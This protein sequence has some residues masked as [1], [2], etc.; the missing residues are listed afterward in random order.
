MSGAVW[1]TKSPEKGGGRDVG[2][3]R[4]R[5]TPNAGRRR[6]QPS[7]AAL[8]FPSSSAGWLAGECSAFDAWRCRVVQNTPLENWRTGELENTPRRRS[9]A[10]NSRLRL[11]RAHLPPAFP[12]VWWRPLHNGARGG[13]PRAQRS[14]WRRHERR[15]WVGWHG[16]CWRGAAGGV[17]VRGEPACRGGGQVRSGGACPSVCSAARF[18]DTRASRVCVCDERSGQDVC[19][20]PFGVSRGG[21]IFTHFANQHLVEP[22]LLGG[23]RAWVCIAYL[24]RAAEW[25]PSSLGAKPEIKQARI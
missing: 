19:V 25:R 20:Q 23:G 11:Q 16:K 1:G 17:C 22:A 3:A 13:G 14:T 6:Q 18:P 12:F 8:W 10:A 2:G 5:G 4:A 15:Q 7:P 24:A 9:G 21:T